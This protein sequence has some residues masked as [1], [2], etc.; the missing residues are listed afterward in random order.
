M[1]ESSPKR[2]TGAKTLK[3]E[4]GVP[5]TRNLEALLQRRDTV[6]IGRGVECDVVVQDAKASRRHCKL[7]REAGG[8][9]LEDLGSR[10][11][12]FVNGQRIDQ[13]VLLKP[14]QTFKVGDTVFY[15]SPP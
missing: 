5:E 12:T 2:D 1:P 9:R 13:S 8:F 10:N 7:A 3:G 15:L 4:P 14:S 6:V 11:G